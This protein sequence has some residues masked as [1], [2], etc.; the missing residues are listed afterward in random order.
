MVY[1]S[2]DLELDSFT[3]GEDIL[4]AAGRRWRGG[5]RKMDVRLPCFMIGQRG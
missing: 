3:Q 2:W 1:E 5:I 4:E